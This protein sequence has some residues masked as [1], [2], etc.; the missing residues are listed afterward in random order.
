MNAL[1]LLP[2]HYTV[3]HWMDGRMNGVSWCS[4]CSISKQRMS[5]SSGTAVTAAGEPE[6]AQAG[7]NTRLLARLDCS[8]TLSEA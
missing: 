7:K 5:Q 8:H 3:I 1:L 4:A 2:G 6:G